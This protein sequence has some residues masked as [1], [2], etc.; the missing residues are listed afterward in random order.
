MFS[1]DKFKVIQTVDKRGKPV[2]KTSTKELEDY[3]EL[4][5]NETEAG[6]QSSGSES[7]SDENQQENVNKE[8]DEM[9]NSVITSGHEMPMNVKEKLQ[10]LE[11]D[12][13]RGEATLL[14]D[15][16]SDEEESEDEEIFIEHVWG[17]LDRNAETTE[18][19]SKR[20]AACNMDWDKIRAVDIMVL[21]NSFLPPG[22]SILSVKVRSQIKISWNHMF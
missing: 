13:L 1:D 4:Q 6:D 12:Y 18:D 3:Y 2:V 5:E 7:D 21:C 9:G 17:E 14:T 22:G 8:I 20:L 11:V 10:N 19:S 15:S 16:S